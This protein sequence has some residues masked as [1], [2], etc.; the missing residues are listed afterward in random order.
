MKV[1]SM[2]GEMVDFTKYLAQNEDAIAVGNAKMNARGDIVGPGGKVIK[3]REEIAAEYH[4]SNPKAVKQVSIKDLAKEIL[5]TP[6]EAVKAIREKKKEAAA[7]A[8]VVAESST[9]ETKTDGKK[10]RLSDSE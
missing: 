7:A 10:R 2:R 9:E 6:T 5:P 4:R 3:K 8:A 1:Q